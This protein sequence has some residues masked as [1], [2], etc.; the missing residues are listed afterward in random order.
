[1]SLSRFAVA[2]VSWSR[3]IRDNLFRELYNR[4]NVSAFCLKHFSEEEYYRRLTHLVCQYN[5]LITLFKKA[6]DLILSVIHENR[7]NVLHNDINTF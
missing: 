5:H 2:G 3:Q 7:N 6:L 4:R 1:M